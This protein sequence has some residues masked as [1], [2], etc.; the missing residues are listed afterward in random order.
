MTAVD[1]FQN[2]FRPVVLADACA[3]HAGPDY[4]EAGLR[5]LER[6]IGRRQIA[7]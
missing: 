3:S 1:L 2:G 7:P 5:L 6:L 4:H